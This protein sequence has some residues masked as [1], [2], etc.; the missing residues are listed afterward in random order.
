M[1]CGRG[2]EMQRKFDDLNREVVYLSSMVAAAAKFIDDELC[3]ELKKFIHNEVRLQLQRAQV[4]ARIPLMEQSVATSLAVPHS[5]GGSNNDQPEC[6]VSP[7]V[8]HPPGLDGSTSASSL[9]SEI[10]LPGAMY[11]TVLFCDTC[12]GGTRCA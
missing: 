4:Q 3:S 7:C 2:T 11:W 6:E 12:T 1:Q 10:A 9:P 5:R 8:P